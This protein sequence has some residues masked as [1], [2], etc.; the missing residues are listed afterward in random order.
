[1]PNYDKHKVT[2]FSSFNV[3]EI[4][5]INI[6]ATMNTKFIEAIDTCVFGSP[7]TL[8][9][10]T[11]SMTTACCELKRT[12]PYCHDLIQQKQLNKWSHIFFN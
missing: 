10:P 1:M 5:L 8:S 7:V 4:T 3:H 9:T 2:H 11:S 12:S 6:L